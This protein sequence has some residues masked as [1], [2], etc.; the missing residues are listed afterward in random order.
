[1]KLCRFLIILLVFFMLFP[2]WV[3]AQ[4]Y[5]FDEPDLNTRIV[6]D[7][8][9]NGFLVIGYDLND[10]GVADF[11][12]LRMVFQ[13]YF[14][15]SSVSEMVEWYPDKEIFTVLYKDSNFYYI[16][17][18][19]P[20]FYVVD[21][22]EDGIWDLIYKDILQDTVNGNETFYDSPSGMFTPKIAKFDF[23]N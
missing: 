20:T 21:L 9:P 7:L 8:Q 17:E 13:N 12:S 4:P 3:L 5:L 23:I 1:M 19:A 18:K 2:P 10:N 11:F 16:T 15:N 22:N 14:S 6:W